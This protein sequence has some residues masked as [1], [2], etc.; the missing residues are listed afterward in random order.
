[1]KG[2]NQS[3][4]WFAITLSKI[5]EK[6]SNS[7]VFLVPILS[8]PEVDLESQSASLDHIVPAFRL[9]ESANGSNGFTLVGS[10]T[11]ATGNISHTMKVYTFL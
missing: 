1:M 7:I 4:Y 2:T 8:S 10:E 9:F 5:F 3:A 6:A 11:P